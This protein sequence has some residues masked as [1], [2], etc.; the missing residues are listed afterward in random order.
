M[1]K[2]IDRFV[3]E[4]RR[5]TQRIDSTF[6]EVS[7]NRRKNM[8]FGVQEFGV[9]TSVEVYTRD[10]GN[11]LI[12]GHPNAK[13]G[14]G[15]GQSG[16]LRASWSLETDT[17]ASEA[18]TVN[19]RNII[20]DALDGDA[21][22]AI[23]EIA[24]G[25]GSQDANEGNS[26]MQSETGREHAW[27]KQG[28][29]SNSTLAQA[30]FLFHQYGDEI[31]ECGVYSGT[32]DLFNRITFS[33]INPTKEQEVRIEVLFEVGG[34]GRGNSAI[35]NDGRDAVAET[36]RSTDTPIGIERI[37]FGTDDTSP[38]NND[39]S[40]GNKIF[41]V[42]V[43][44]ETNAEVVT[45]HAVVFKDEPSSQPVTLQ[46]LGAVDNTG[47]LIWRAVFDSFEKKDDNEIEVYVSFR[48]K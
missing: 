27:G 45:A 36:I 20:R 34:D 18:F 41:D 1:P 47:R 43:E 16:D 11:G 46:E 2:P 38:A 37:A 23:A 26:A 25:S 19:G 48:A 32:D 14:S 35:T 5:A 21:N 10:L 29:F 30:S 12:S 8:T 31:A 28:Q 17:E 6:I 15:R 9:P 39:S 7:T 42:I 44:R 40:L 24:V 13:H 4:N 3:S 33:T 22:A